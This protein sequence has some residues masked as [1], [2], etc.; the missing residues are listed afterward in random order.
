MTHRAPAR[1]W[2][3][4]HSRPGNSYQGPTLRCVLGELS[5]RGG[6][7]ERDRTGPPWHARCTTAMEVTTVAIIVVVAMLTL[8]VLLRTRDD[9]RIVVYSAFPDAA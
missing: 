9:F 3:A 7:L 6:Y 8:V 2:K 5:L 4:L 1:R